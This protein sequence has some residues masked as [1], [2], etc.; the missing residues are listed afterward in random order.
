[1]S[2]TT[3]LGLKKDTLG[4]K[5]DHR[6]SKGFIYN[7]FQHF[8]KI[9]SNILFAIL[10]YIICRDMTF[11]VWGHFFAAIYLFFTRFGQFV[12]GSFVFHLLWGSLRKGN[13]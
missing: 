12:E 9:L 13:Y 10:Y 7:I 11:K 5:G 6:G 3:F 1:M 4:S 8:S 2:C